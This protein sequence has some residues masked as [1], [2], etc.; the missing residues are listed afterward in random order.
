MAII[1]LVGRP[2]VQRGQFLFPFL[3]SM[4]VGARVVLVDTSFFFPRH[5]RYNIVSRFF[6]CHTEF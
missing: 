5:S 1:R 6:V 2:S 4:I 3:S